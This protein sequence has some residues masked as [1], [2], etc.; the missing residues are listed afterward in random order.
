VQFDCRITTSNTLGQVSFSSKFPEK[1]DI[2][3]LRLS[4]LLEDALAAQPGLKLQ[5]SDASSS[6]NTYATP[7]LS[8]ALLTAI[9]RNDKLAGIKIADPHA[10]YY[11]EFTRP[12]PDPA[13]YPSPQGAAGSPFEDTNLKLW[14]LSELHFARALHLGE[15]ED[16]V[17]H[18]E[19]RR[20]DLES[21]GYE[22]RP[23]VVDYLARYPLNAELLA[24]VDAL[25]ADPASPIYRS[26]YYHWSGES[27]DFDVTNLNGIGSCVN[28]KLLHL[29]LMCED[30]LDLA[31]L[32]EAASIEKIGIDLRRGRFVNLDV[33][34]QL[35]RLKEVI[36]SAHQGNDSAVIAALKLKGVKVTVTGTTYNN[37]GPR[38]P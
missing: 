31:P 6:Q 25:G 34:S 20:I 32:L 26:I 1:Y 24:R 19:G 4:L 2:E 35:P 36:S 37:S 7:L 5:S 10:Q 12:L 27:P 3:G 28:L 13:L 15:P 33:L 30:G 9:F 38:L 14:V 21:E 8:G 17:A 22:P 23:A 29:E 11:D 18:I 16:L